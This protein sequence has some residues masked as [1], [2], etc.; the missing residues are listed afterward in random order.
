MRPQLLDRF[1][2]VVEVTGPRDPAVRVEIVRRR[3]A[4]EA[5]AEGFATRWE[6]EQ[7]TLR[8]Q[9]ADA[10]ARLADVV[11]P[12]GLLT[13][14]SQL[15]CEFETDGLRADLALHK[16]ARARTALHGRGE[17]AMEDIRAAAE[18]VLPHRRKRKPFEQPNLAPQQLDDSMAKLQKKQTD[19]GG[20]VPPQDASGN[21]EGE[22]EGEGEVPQAGERTFEPG[23]A[24]PIRRIEIASA[25]SDGLMPRGRRNP[26]PGAQRGRT[27][28]AVQDRQATDIAF[29][30]TV[31]AAAGRGGLI[32]GRLQIGPEDLH[33]KVR[34][35]RTGSL[36]LFVV[37]ASGSMAALKRM[38]LVK[39]TVLGLL[40]SAYEQRDLVGVI[41][42]RGP[43]ATVLLAP[44]SS[45]QQAEDC[46][47]RAAHRR[48]HAAGAR[49][50]PGRR[51]RGAGPAILQ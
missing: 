33:R 5:D 51:G 43:Q 16:A 46:A 11:L 14:I 2:L 4:F 6:M 42:F 22:D 7:A 35:G 28:R 37:D 18:L 40:R 38:E 44:T 15:C 10:R 3:L 48:T 19:E 24:Q 41:A 31:R 9:I 20:N 47:A 17:V 39:G 49:L 13:F 8:T 45:V 26:L 32:D 50:D 30:A 29:A 25:G 1:G 34:D 23:L 36:L 12:E 27:V 21:R